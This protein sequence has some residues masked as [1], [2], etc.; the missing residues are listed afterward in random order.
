[1]TRYFWYHAS[2]QVVII[3]DDNAIFS[4]FRFF[5]GMDGKFIF[6][7]RRRNVAQ[8]TDLEEYLLKMGKLFEIRQVVAEIMTFEIREKADFH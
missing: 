2:F 8:S 1:M 3:G 7:A 6:L 5:I 4:I